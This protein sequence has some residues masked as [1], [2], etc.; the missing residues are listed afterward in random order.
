MFVRA[1][2]LIDRLRHTPYIIY[3]MVHMLENENGIDLF[4]I[5]VIIIKFVAKC[6]LLVLG[7]LLYAGSDI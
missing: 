2:A 4:I 7:A 6:A 3:D 1:P 5:N